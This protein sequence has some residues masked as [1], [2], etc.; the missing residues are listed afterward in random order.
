MSK[1]SPKASPAFSMA[2]YIW[3]DGTEPVQTTRSKARVVQ[4]PENPSP[5]DFPE[6]S[7]DG[8]STNQADGGNSDCIIKPVCVVND[9]F[10]GH[11]NYLVM[12]EVFEDAEG[13]NGD[14]TV[15]PSNA[16]AQLRAVLDAGAD[17]LE[18]SC[19]FEL[20][21]TFMQNGKPLGFPEAGYPE[22][23]GP[24]YCAAG[25]GKVAGREIVELHAA[26]CMEAGLAFY[27]IN[28]E[29]MLGQ[30]EFQIGYRGDDTEDTSIM[31]MADHTWIARWMLDRLSE[32][33]DV[34]VSYDNKPVKGDW[35]GTGMHT[36]FSTKDTRDKTKGR[37]AIKAAT[38]ALGKKHDAHIKLYGAG[39]DERLT[40]AHETCD[41]HTFKVGDADRGCSIR[42][43]KPVAIK[44]YG[45]FEDRRPGGNADP[46]LVV[47]RIAATVA[48]VDENVFYFTQWPREQNTAPKLAAVAA[49]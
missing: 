29:V 18:A 33:Y 47:A 16:R 36:N 11:G 14:V 12:C 15:H 1:T 5:E 42:I 37:A 34:E 23:Q 43:P 10:R 7:Y 20:E 3:I 22:P 32:E 28:A 40:G 21:Y 44:G 24:Y 41:I 8:S 2:E 46:Y 30:W 26:M 48:D 9:P 49:E 31:T 39:N 4:V 38:D 17:K 6:W 13:T 45:Y 19:G 25:A 35:N 27:G